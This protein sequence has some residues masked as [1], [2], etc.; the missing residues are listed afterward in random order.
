M[1]LRSYLGDDPESGDRLYGEFRPVCDRRGNV[2][3]L[4]DESGALAEF[5]TYDGFGRTAIWAPGGSPL[6]QSAVGN[7]FLFSS[8][9]FD[10]ATGLYDFNA[11]WYDPALGRFISPDPLGFVD[12][13]N[14]YAYCAGDPVNFVDPWGLCAE[15]GYLR[16]ESGFGPFGYYYPN[17]PT[18]YNGLY[19]DVSNSLAWGFNTVL[20]LA[21]P[22]QQ[23][24]QYAYENWELYARSVDLAGS[25]EAAFL[26]LVAPQ[27]GVG[28]ALRNGGY[29]AESVSALARSGC[30]KLAA[31]MAGRVVPRSGPDIVYRRL[32][33]AER[34]TALSEGLSPRSPGAD[35]TPE[36][37]ILGARGTPYI[38]TTR[39]YEAALNYNRNATPIV[40]IDLSKVPAEAV[41]FTRPETLS[42]LTEKQAIYN[43]S[44]DAEVLIKGSIPPEAI[45]R[46]HYP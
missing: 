13:P 29:L 46:V 6:A 43:A 12:G 5:Y 41:D 21:V 30:G 45:G 10:T 34:P 9:L 17:R 15:G 36:Q 40:E 16:V 20:R 22:F 37:H 35:I 18:W 42:T 19:S 4:F 31:R 32:H 23:S 2:V 25:D 44:R 8:K 26:A 3:A 27:A 38:S 7:T 39:D 11:R 14:P 24:H 33:P 28:M 1:L